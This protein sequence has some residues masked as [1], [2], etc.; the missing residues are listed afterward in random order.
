MEIDPENELQC[1]SLHDSTP[2]CTG[3]VYEQRL[4][5]SSETVI[6]Q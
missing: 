2:V 5:T 6:G 4:E 1:I 3:L